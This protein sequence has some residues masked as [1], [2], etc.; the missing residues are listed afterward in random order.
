M[1]QTLIAES[2]SRIIYFEV[3]AEMYF[4]NNTLLLC[5]EVFVLY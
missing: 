2:E 3:K 4:T 1:R 5:H